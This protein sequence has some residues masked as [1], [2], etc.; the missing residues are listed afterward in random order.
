MVVAVNAIWLIALAR[1]TTDAV[2]T[3]EERTDTAH[4]AQRL[5]LPR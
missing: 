3:L 1:W 2:E 5:E 4:P